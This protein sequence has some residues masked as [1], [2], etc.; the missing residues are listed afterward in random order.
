MSKRERRT[1]V[2]DTTLYVGPTST[3]VVKLPDEW[4]AVTSERLAT[5]LGLAEEGM[6]GASS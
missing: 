3:A 6:W 1:W 5:A 2:Q 4:A